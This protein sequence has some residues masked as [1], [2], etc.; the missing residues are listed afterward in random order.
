MH[1][2]AL[3]QR[4]LSLLRRRPTI[5]LPPLCIQKTK[6][7]RDRVP[8]RALA[9]GIVRSSGSGEGG[10]LTVSC[11]IISGPLPW[12][13]VAPPPLLILPL[14]FRPRITLG[15]DRFL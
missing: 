7:K 2:F 6:N 10:S 14:L 11:G 4:P 3:R 13:G 1:A 12:H 8:F 9:L 5:L 15:R